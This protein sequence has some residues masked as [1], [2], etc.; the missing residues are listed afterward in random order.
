MDSDLLLTI[1]VMGFML[2]LKL[3]CNFTERF[4]KLRNLFM[5]FTDFIFCCSISGI[6]AR[7]REQYCCA[8]HRIH[9]IGSG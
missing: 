5:L 2:S 9:I 6:L 4:V 8:K 7:P 1:S 3:S